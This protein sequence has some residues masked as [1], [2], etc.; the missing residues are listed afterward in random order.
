MSAT[1]RR[2]LAAEDEG[3]LWASD[4]YGLTWSRG[5]LAG[6]GAM[7]D[8]EWRGLCLADAY[9]AGK[10]YAL[11]FD[12]TL[13]TTLDGGATW[14]ES[15]SPVANAF[16]LGAAGQSLVA[17]GSPG[18]VWTSTDGG[19]TWTMRGLARRDWRAC[20]AAADGLT[21]Y[22]C[23][24]GSGCWRSSDGGA[25][26]SEMPGLGSGSWT[27]MSI[28]YGG[29]VVALCEDHGSIRLSEDGGGTWLDM[30]AVQAPRRG[31]WFGV[32]VSASGHN[33]VAAQGGGSLWTYGCP[34][35]ESS[36][37]EGDDCVWMRR[38]ELGSGLWRVVAMASNGSRMVAAGRGT[39]V[40]LG[41][42]FG[43][44]WKSWRAP[45][46]AG[47]AADSAGSGDESSSSL[48]SEAFNE[49]AVWTCAAISADGGVVALGQ[50]GG[51]LSLSRDFGETWSQTG[52]A[53]RWSSVSMS[54]DGGKLIA[55]TL[56]G[57]VYLKDGGP[58]EPCAGL[59]EGRWLSVLMDPSG[60]RA[61]AACS[62]GRVH[63]LCLP[64]LIDASSS[65]SSSQSSMAV[66]DSSFSSSS[67][68]S[69]QT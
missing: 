54:D 64:S 38:G 18:R 40:W 41:E 43:S 16:A 33:I 11:A 35:S 15:A 27:D 5:A 17:A 24:D 26:W 23:A 9:G 32:A 49:A 31:D 55:G 8:R 42:S 53:A 6:G 61:F 29:S 59:P 60:R 68:Q 45:A 63:A 20:C 66:S 19:A 46:A 51:C 22:A 52:P 7:P 12:G 25:E 1:G 58:L 37:S 30:P 14:T 57:Y 50:D 48:S 3:G 4:D 62:M 47:A 65:S 39:G 28:D 67:S 10:A 36:S 69:I 13:A 34:P 21:M 2:L 44:S 56:G